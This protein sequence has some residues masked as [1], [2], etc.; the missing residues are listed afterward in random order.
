MRQENK[1]I[2]QFSTNF[3]PAK[4]QIN[5]SQFPRK[6]TYAKETLH[7]TEMEFEHSTRIFKT[8]SIAYLQIPT[9]LIHRT[10]IWSNKSSLVP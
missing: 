1:V 3:K 4:K 9:N 5:I 10:L 2:L 7:H 6:T 8:F